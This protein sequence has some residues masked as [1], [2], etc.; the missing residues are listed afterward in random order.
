MLSKNDMN[1]KEV[2][3]FIYYDNYLVQKVYIILAHVG[4]IN[5]TGISGSDTY[6]KVEFRITYSLTEVGKDIAY[7]GSLIRDYQKNFK[8]YEIG[9]AHV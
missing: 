9:R 6:K 2:Q 5:I 1:I 7:S 8:K 3:P 4:D